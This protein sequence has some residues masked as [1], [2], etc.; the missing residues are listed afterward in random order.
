M[1]NPVQHPGEV[2]TMKNKT[3]FLNTILAL[4]LG[5]TLLAMVIVGTFMPVII[6]P[7]INIPN[8]VLICLA[9]L[10]IDHYVTKGVKRCYYCVAGF[11]AVTFFLLPLAAGFVTV[12]EALKLALTGGI[13][14]TV[15]T[16][17]F[18][19]MQDRIATGPAKKLSPVLSAICLYLASQALMG[20]FW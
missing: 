9:A 11:S 15:V 14:F 1:W 17:M 5:V 10:V 18:T 16:W 2:E 19:S 6:L 3:Y 12:A 4:V 13:L 20:I 7:K 8:L